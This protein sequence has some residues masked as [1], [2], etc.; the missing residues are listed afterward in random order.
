MKR[1]NVSSSNLASIGYDENSQ[2]LEI[3]FNN[4]RIYQY[5]NVP[6]IEFQNLKN[7]NSHGK[8]FI[9]KIKDFYQYQQIR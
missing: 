1:I 2:I 8:Y 7:A 6:S 5:L 3:E 9:S 4:G